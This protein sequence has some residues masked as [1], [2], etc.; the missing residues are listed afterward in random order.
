MT[1]GPALSRGVR[2]AFTGPSHDPAILRRE[3]DETGESMR[4]AGVLLPRIPSEP[5]GTPAPGTSTRAGGRPA[6]APHEVV[7]LRAPACHL[8]EDALGALGEF[9]RTFPL[10]VRVVELTSPEGMELQARH[11]PAMPPAV[12]L[13][14][15]LFSVGR[16]PRRKLRRLLDGGR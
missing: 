2:A 9:S 11:R 12:I 10:A 13:D 15:R 4:A 5:P 7:V 8:C 14:G 1:G 6:A 3:V 16:L